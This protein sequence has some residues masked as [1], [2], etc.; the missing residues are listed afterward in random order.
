MTVFRKCNAFLKKLPLN[1]NITTQ[2]CN[3]SNFSGKLVFDG[4]YISVKGYKHQIPMIW[5][6]DY[7]THDIPH[8]ML[9]PSENYL[10]CKSFFATLKA[11]GYPLKYLVSDDNNNIKLAAADIFP[12]ALI[13]TCWTHY[14]NNIRADLNIRSS[15]KYFHFFSEIENVFKSRLCEVE[16]MWKVQAIYPTF[17]NDKKCLDWLTDLMHKRKQLTNYHMFENCPNTTN[18]IEVYNSHLKQRLKAIKGFQSYHSAHSWLNAYVIK[19][20]LKSFTD[21]N[22]K[23][24]HLNGHCSLEKTIKKSLKLPNIF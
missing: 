5:A 16:L 1:L 11:I 15:F 4:T 12:N 19:R 7:D 9:V 8:F 20:R 14:L 2:Y 17:C 22:T 23:F 18:L 21:C 24:K 10:A 13:Q 6:I 3:M